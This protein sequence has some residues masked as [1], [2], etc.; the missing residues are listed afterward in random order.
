LQL[1]LGRLAARALH[2]AA[3]A[4]GVDAALAERAVLVSQ[5]AR[6]AQQSLH[7]RWRYGYQLALALE[8]EFALQHLRRLADCA[9]DC[10]SYGVDFLRR[11][12]CLLGA[13]HCRSQVALA[14]SAQPLGV[15]A[16]VAAGL[17]GAACCSRYD[18]GWG[19]HCH[20]RCHFGLDAGDPRY[21]LLAR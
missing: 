1:L 17:A 19:F 8:F 16:V 9:G 14:L 2:V 7:A 3:E 12:Y 13:A 5:R 18:W 6:R 10:D 20:Y 11:L 21:P 15:V 4:A